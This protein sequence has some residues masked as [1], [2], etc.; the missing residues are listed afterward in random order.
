VRHIG[1][2]VKTNFRDL[3]NPSNGS[4]PKCAVRV[5]T[6]L[7]E[8]FVGRTSVL[9]GLLLIIIR[10]RRTNFRQTFPKGMWTLVMSLFALRSIVA[11][12]LRNH[13]FKDAHTGTKRRFDA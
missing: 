6:F 2:H 13:L 12:R 11:N 8:M 4:F 10:P 1:S 3:I 5:S 7:L 9:G